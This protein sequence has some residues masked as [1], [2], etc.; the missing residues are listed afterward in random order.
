MIH[1]DSAMDLVQREDVAHDTHIPPT[2]GVHQRH[3]SIFLSPLADQMLGTLAHRNTNWMTPPGPSVALIHLS[4]HR[5]DTPILDW[6]F[7]PLPLDMT[8]EINRV[9][10]SGFCDM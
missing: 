8:P 3:Q 4:G 7:A 10:H 9:D 1:H 6:C 2:S 5:D